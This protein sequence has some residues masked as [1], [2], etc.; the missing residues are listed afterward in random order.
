[1]S[2]NDFARSS[3][4]RRRLAQAVPTST[5][6]RLYQCPAGKAT[7]IDAIYVTNIHS[8]STDVSIHHIVPGET[9]GTSNALYY[10]V[11]V[12]KGSVLIDDAPKYLL[13]GDQIMV[14]SSTGAHVTVTVYGE[15][16]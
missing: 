2:Y 1:M 13:P 12:A 4:P 16:G 8:G 5:T 6:L 14:S 11:T 10:Q 15:E 7:R 3:T 9:A